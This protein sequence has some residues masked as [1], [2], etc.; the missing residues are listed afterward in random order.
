MKHGIFTFKNDALLCWRLGP[1]NAIRQKHYSKDVTVNGLGGSHKPPASRGIWAFPYPHYDLFFCWHRWESLLPK[2]FQKDGLEHSPEYW[3]EREKR[4]K[5]IRR[6]NR[7]STFYANGFYSHIF[8][9]GRTPYEEWFYWESARD[10]AEEAKKHIISI[11]KW[12]EQIFKCSYTQDH[13]ELFVP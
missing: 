3:Q 7:P 10:W 5:E 2:R 8:P 1:I 4:L 9:N 12:N 6:N 13:L 11:E